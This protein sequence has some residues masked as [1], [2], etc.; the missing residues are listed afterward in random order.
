[1]LTVTYANELLAL[2]KCLANERL[3]NMQ[4]EIEIMDDPI[5]RSGVSKKTG[6]NYSITMQKAYLH[7]PNEKYPTSFEFFLRNGEVF[8]PG[9][10]TL[11]ADAFYVDREGR[12]SLG[13]ERGLVPLAQPAGIKAA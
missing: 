6:N 10:Y 13:I 1:M 9:R 3:A 7:N 8:K 5:T 11:G 2:A 4:V 12:L